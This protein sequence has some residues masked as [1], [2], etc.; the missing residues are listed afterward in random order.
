MKKKLIHLKN[1]RNSYTNGNELQFLENMVLFFIFF[2]IFFKKGTNKTLTLASR[3]PIWVDGQPHKVPRV[4]A[5]PLEQWG[6][7]QA[8]PRVP[9]GWPGYNTQ[10]S[11]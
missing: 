3:P 6:V 9:Q 11:I 8:T 7:A 5:P 2:Q 10:E 1:E 4:V